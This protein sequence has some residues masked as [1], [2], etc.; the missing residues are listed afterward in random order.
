LIAVWIASEHGTRLGAGDLVFVPMRR[1]ARIGDTVLVL[2]GDRLACIGDLLEA[3]E[4]TVRIDLG[5]DDTEDITPQDHQ[6]CKVACI[7]LP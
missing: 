6:V 4:Q 1:P 2:K 5:R 3:F 7:V